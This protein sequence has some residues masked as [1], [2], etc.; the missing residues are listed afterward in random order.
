[1]SE[2]EYFLSVKNIDIFHLMP[3][4]GSLPADVLRG[5]FLFVTHS[6]LPLQAQ[7]SVLRFNQ[8]NIFNR[9]RF[10]NKYLMFLEELNKLFRENWSKFLTARYLGT[11][12]LYRGSLFQLFG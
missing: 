8:G 10:L 4:L 7:E 11:L 2:L 3:K 12:W 6:F 9:L 5:L 1:M